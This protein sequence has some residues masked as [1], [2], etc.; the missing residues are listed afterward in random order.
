MIDRRTL[1]KGSAG[2]AIG[3]VLAGCSANA[4]GTLNL[5][6]LEGAIPSVVLRSFQNQIDTPVKFQTVTQV[7]TAFQTLQRWQQPEA[8]DAWE[9]FMPWRQ[10]N[11][12]A[13]SS[14]L[15]SLGD[16]WLTEA[17]TQNLIEPLT[18]TAETLNLL[19]DRWQAFGRRDRNA[20]INSSEQLW[21]V[22]YKLQTLV[23]VYRQSQFPTQSGQK[24]FSSWQDLLAP[25]LYQ[26][27]ALPSHPNIIIGL[28][29][30]LQTNSFNPDTSVA[31][32]EQSLAQLE[33]QL[34]ASF[35]KLAP[36]VKTYDSSTALKA[37]INEDV[38]AVVAW[39]GDVDTALKRYQDLRVAIPDEGSLLS[40][41]MWVQP[42][43]TLLSNAAEAWVSFCWQTEPATEL[44][45][46]QKGIS[47]V[48]LA[49]DSQ[50]P[51]TLT[52]A[53][54]ALSALRKSELLFPLS[55]SVQSA[56]TKFWQQITAS[57]LS[58]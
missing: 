22:P 41:D 31:E 13:A 43:G 6:L 47:P 34:A 35:D 45:I 15:V 57:E 38:K 40:M 58:D 29:Q 20:Q 50:I 14:N 2:L 26:N 39:S 25:N 4:E 23:V 3:S 10:S 11:A 46:T 48:F 21:G 27:I 51:E 28:L 18:L 56:Y 9:R 33:Q 30:K 52:K 37:L 8:T 36:Q 7:Q 53:Q 19:P 1:L 42:K 24:P 16:Y 12:R 44:S 49:A 5:L 55:K 54:P 32:T 17:I